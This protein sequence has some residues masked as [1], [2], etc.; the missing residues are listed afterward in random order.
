LPK[1][2]VFRRSLEQFARQL[3]LVDANGI[4]SVI[5][6]ILFLRKRPGNRIDFSRTQNE[7]STQAQSGAHA[8]VDAVTTAWG[9][10]MKKVLLA[11]VSLIAVGMI[12]GAYADTLPPM[13]KTFCDPYKN[14]SCLDSYLG[15]DF[16]TR[17]INYYRLEWGHE[18]AP[19]DPKAPPS[20]RDYWPATP[21]STPPMPF[22]VPR[23]SA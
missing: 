5:L 12:D 20:R 6:V 7:N 13:G 22:T 14:Y 15:D 21:Q 3:M 18:A 11:G 10:T 23:P 8:S 9:N 19:S 17:F 4:D 1:R 16:I 2:H